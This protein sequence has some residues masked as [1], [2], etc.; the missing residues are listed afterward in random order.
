VR[1]QELTPERLAAELQRLFS[2]PEV[3][4]VAAA[5]GKAMAETEAVRKLADLAEELA[6]TKAE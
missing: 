3:L 1:Q 4:A 5:K 6:R 2:S